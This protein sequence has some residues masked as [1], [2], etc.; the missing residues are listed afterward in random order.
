MQQAAMQHGDA[1]FADRVALITGGASGIGLA[2]AERMA[3]EGARVIIW[4]I[5]HGKRAAAAERLGA[6]AF[7]QAVDVTDETAVDG[8]MGL[9]VERSGRLD[10]LVNCAGAIGPHGPFMAYGAADWRKTI[11]LNLTGTFLVTRAASPHLMRRGYG[12]V[13]NIGSP[14]GKEGNQNQAAYSAAKAGVIGLTKSMSKDLA[15]HGVLVNSVCP[16]TTDSDLLLQVPDAHKAAVLAKIPLGRFGR[17]DEI[18]ALICWVASEECSFAAGAC[19][20][21]SGGRSD[22]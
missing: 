5:D 14:A 21:F 16:A 6:A 18:A 2:V 12:R 8:G 4:D 11:E 3:R 1:R 10:I 19:F 13:V 15:A 17:V 20:D 7:C 22:Y 9:A